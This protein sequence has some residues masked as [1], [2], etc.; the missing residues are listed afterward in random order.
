MNNKHRI[1]EAREVED[2]EGTAGANSNLPNAFPD[3]AEW[4]PVN[5]LY[6]VLNTIDLVTCLSPSLRRK[7]T[8]IVEGA[9][10]EDGWLHPSINIQHF[11]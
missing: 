1:V 9:P 6:S 11:V 2:P 7:G 3:C 5:R 10:A 8:Q 4:L